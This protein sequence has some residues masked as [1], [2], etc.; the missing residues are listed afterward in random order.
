MSVE[1]GPEE[2]TTTCVLTEMASAGA[3]ELSRPDS[4]SVGQPIVFRAVDFGLMPCVLDR[5]GASIPVFH[6]FAVMEENM[7]FR[8]VCDAL[9]DISPG[10]VEAVSEFIY[11][12]LQTN[13]A[14]VSV[15]P[16]VEQYG[17]GRSMFTKLSQTVTARMARLYDAVGGSYRLW[18]T[19]GLLEK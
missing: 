6:V 17:H 14:G 2:S 16:L 1:V 12:A 4:A 10:T 13:L 19:T 3:E 18:R 8:E 5:S 7:D 15:E 11:Q 9:P